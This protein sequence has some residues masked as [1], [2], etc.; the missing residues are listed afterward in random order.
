MKLIQQTAILSD[1]NTSS[2]PYVTVK[3]GIAKEFQ[4]ADEEI[5]EEQQ[6]LHVKRQSAHVTPFLFHEN[7]AAPL[8]YGAR[9]TMIISYDVVIRAPTIDSHLINE[10]LSEPHRNQCIFLVNEFHARVD[11]WRD[12]ELGF[13]ADRML[14]EPNAGGSSII[15]EVLSLEV[16]ERLYDAQL[17]K[18]EMEIEY[19]H[20]GWKKTDYMVSIFSHV[21][22]V[23]VTRAFKFKGTYCLEDA[24]TILDKKLHGINVSSQ[25]VLTRDRWERQ[26]LHIWAPSRHVAQLIWEEYQRLGSELHSNTIVIVTIAPDAPYIWTNRDNRL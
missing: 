22:G 14:H 5:D 15:S 25:G 8:S 9:G 7:N 17:L 21:L 4:Q 18:T 26:I 3:A 20:V 13:G 1:T 24:R 19:A 12:I 10:I 6:Q 2:V 11:S 16:L 23:S